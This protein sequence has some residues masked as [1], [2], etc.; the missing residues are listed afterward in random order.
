MKIIR[1]SNYNIETEAQ[2][3]VAEGIKH[4]EQGLVMLDALQADP[5]RSDFD[6]FELVEDNYK[7]WRGMADIVGE[8]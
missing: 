3:I 7:L 1:T 5:K 2:Y 4:R 8:G 6:W